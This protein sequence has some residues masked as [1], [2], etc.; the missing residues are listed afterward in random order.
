MQ[1]NPIESI[2]NQP[3]AQTLTPLITFRI[4]NPKIER[5]ELEISCGPRQTYVSLNSDYPCYQFDCSS[6]WKLLKSPQRIDYEA[7]AI[8]KNNGQKSLVE[9]GYFLPVENILWFVRL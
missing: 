1:E 3:P 5:I 6:I 2:I 8:Y 7:Q 9:K 4:E